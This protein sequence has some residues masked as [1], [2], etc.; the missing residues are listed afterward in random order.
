MRRARTYNTPKKFTVIANATVI[1]LLQSSEADTI[2]ELEYLLGR[3]IGLEVENRFN[4]EQ[5][6]ILLD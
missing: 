4:Q 2:A 5:Y 1:E 3:P 6:H